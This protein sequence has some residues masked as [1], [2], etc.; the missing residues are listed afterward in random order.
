[1]SLEI[2]KVIHGFKDVL[3]EIGEGL[4]FFNMGPDLTM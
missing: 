2:I 3:L 1:M 4:M